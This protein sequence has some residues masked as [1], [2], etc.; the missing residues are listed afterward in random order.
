MKA[1]KFWNGK[2]DA[3]ELE[4]FFR[5]VAQKVTDTDER[6]ASAQEDSTASSIEDLR[7]D[8]NDLLA[9]LRMSGLLSE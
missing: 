3:K 2:T 5:D 7:A 4:T 6:V 8:F 1:P 9:K